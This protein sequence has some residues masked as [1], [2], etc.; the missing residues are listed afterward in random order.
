MICIFFVPSQ[1]KGSLVV[2][3]LFWSADL[4]MFLAIVREVG[5]WAFLYK[6]IKK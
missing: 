3:C 2:T 5:G 4:V 1:F 6:H